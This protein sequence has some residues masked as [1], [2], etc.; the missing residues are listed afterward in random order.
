MVVPEKGFQEDELKVARDYFQ[1]SGYQVVLASR[2]VK[3]ATGMSG[4]MVSIDQDIQ[5]IDL[6]PY[7]A[8]VFVGGEGIY[9]LK[10]HEEPVYQKLA[11]EAADQGMLIGAICLGPWILADA[12]LL[13]GK[14]ATAAET[15]HLGKKGALVAEEDVV[16]D[17]NIITASG[18]SATQEFAEAVVAALESEA[19]SSR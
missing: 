8:V 13:E 12:G 7:Q 9:S 5:G 1:S 6:S 10:L 3:T 15:D 2:G 14:R 19:S 17:G 11:Q 16:V 18:P 4:E